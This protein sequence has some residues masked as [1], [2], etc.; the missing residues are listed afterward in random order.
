MGTDT[1]HVRVQHWSFLAA[2]AA[3]SLRF[4]FLPYKD[5]RMRKDTRNVNMKK[6]RADKW[7]GS[8]KKRYFGERF[9]CRVLTRDAI[10]EEV[11]WRYLLFVSWYISQI[12]SAFLFS[13][14][15]S[16]LH[17]AQFT[18]PYFQWTCV[19]STIHPHC[20]SVIECNDIVRQLIK[21]GD[22]IPHS[23]GLSNTPYPE[24]N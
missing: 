14:S 6:K 8:A 12:K 24:A 13:S 20:Q 3:V 7:A 5:K 21:P 22:S 18:S 23:Q 16:T 15:V 4:V 17:Y 2:R 11:R 1:I 10:H 9:C 19:T